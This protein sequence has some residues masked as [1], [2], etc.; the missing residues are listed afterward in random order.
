METTLQRGRA[1]GLK[2]SHSKLRQ[3]QKKNKFYLRKAKNPFHIK[4]FAL[5]LLLKL[6]LAATPGYSQMACSINALLTKRELKKAGFSVQN[7]SS[8]FLC[9]FGPM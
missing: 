4:G 5:Y 9:L 2:T 1:S 6:R 7:A 3:I 8:I